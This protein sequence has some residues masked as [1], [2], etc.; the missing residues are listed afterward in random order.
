VAPFGALV[1]GSPGT[2][3]G[4]MSDGGA[5][6]D[7]VIFR[8][9]P[10]SAGIVYTPLHSINDHPPIGDLLLASDGR[11]YGTSR[12]GGV[13]LYGSIFRINTDGTGFQVIHSFNKN[14]GAYPEAG[15]VQ[16]VDGNLYGVTTEGGTDNEGTVFR[17]DLGLPNPQQN[18]QP[19]AINDFGFSSGSSVPVSVLAND[20]DPD[21]D[22]LTLSIEAQPSS[23]TLAFNT[24]GSITYFPTLGQYN[25]FDQFTYRI[26]DPD[27]LFAT[28]TVTITDDAIPEPWQPTV[29]NGI[30]N[31]DPN[32]S[33]STDTPRG[34]VIIN[35]TASGVFTG[36]LFSQGK[37]YP[38][39]GFF[40]EGDTAIAI[41]KMSKKKKALLFLAQGEGNSLFAAFFGQEQLTG[42]LSPILVPEPPLS[43]SLTTILESDTQE[44]PHGAGYGVVRLLSNGL[45]LG[46]G[47]LGDG[48]KFAW[49]TT[50]V[51]I[52]PTTPA[53]PV[54]SEPV[55]GGFCAG[56]F[57]MSDVGQYQA[58]LKWFRPPA[59]KG[60]PPYPAGFSGEAGGL[61]AV[62][63]PPSKGFAPVDFGTDGLAV[64]GVFGPS[65]DPGA[66]G[67]VSVQ[68]SRLI[69]SDPLK[70]FSINRSNGLFSGKIKA[71]SKT[72]SFKGA[73]IQSL[74][75]GRG[76]CMVDKV[77]STAG[78]A[79]E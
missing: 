41:V 14:N 15:L 57:I 6:S 72:V 26:T 76:H 33:G 47:K 43:Q 10:S 18:R 28:A 25:G 2:F 4:T 20:F 58:Q 16:G 17:I 36:K 39:R 60:A 8:L 55:R 40:D 67:V 29:Y 48:S 78:F 3:Y 50:L 54:F 46:V 27:G 37:R 19:I 71:G 73:I 13:K 21:D 75:V 69:P 30:L 53:I 64:A 62:Y 45:V 32:L 70:S 68:G 42:Y 11:L 77:T 44:L 61:M 79:A 56:H 1:E 9:E 49:G 63:N 5:N 59:T 38:I 51:S 52:D 24:G 74:G 23:G 65:V 12:A 31:L 7:G 35:I 34:Q 66:E 22:W